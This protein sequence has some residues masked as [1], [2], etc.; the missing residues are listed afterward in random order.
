MATGG[1]QMEGSCTC[2]AAARAA[3]DAKEGADAGGGLPASP[4]R[5]AHRV[6]EGIVF[7]PSPNLDLSQRGL[8]HVGEVFKIP[9]LQVSGGS[10][11]CC[12][13]GAVQT[14]GAPSTALAC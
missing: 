1:L 7:S 11:G 5:D 2:G 9:N 6:I 4:A 14:S 13:T 12:H 3:E 10:L 8:R